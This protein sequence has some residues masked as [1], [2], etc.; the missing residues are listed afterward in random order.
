C[1][2]NQVRRL[3]RSLGISLGR[4]IKSSLKALGVYLVGVAELLA[5][6]TREIVRQ[7]K[8]VSDAIAG[9]RML[10]A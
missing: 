9:G 10:P 8:L 6:S 2:Q 1:P 3:L 4:D 7:A 5:P